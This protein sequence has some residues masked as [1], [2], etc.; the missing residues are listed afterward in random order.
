MDYPSSSRH[1]HSRRNVSFNVKNKK[2]IKIIFIFACCRETIEGD[3]DRGL[4][5]DPGPLDTIL[6]RFLEFLIYKI[7]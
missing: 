3:G 2:V 4:D 1:S 5:R 7:H 6:G